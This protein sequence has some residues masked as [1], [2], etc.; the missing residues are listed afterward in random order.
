MED[1]M[2]IVYLNKLPVNF[3]FVSFVS[4]IIKIKTQF[5]NFK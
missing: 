1:N 5:L 2:M 3:A 4:K